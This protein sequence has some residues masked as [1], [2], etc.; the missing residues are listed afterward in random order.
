MSRHY[1]A[2]FFLLVTFAALALPATADIVTFDDGALHTIDAANSFP[3]DGAVIRDSSTGNPTTVVIQPGGSFGSTVSLFDTSLLQLN[4]GFLGSYVEAGD[5]AHIDIISGSVGSGPSAVG[6][7][8]AGT[9]AIYGGVLNGGLA[10]APGGT[11]DLMGGS[12]TGNLV[13]GDNGTIVVHGTDFNMPLG[14]VGPITGLLTGTLADGTSL[15]VN[16]NRDFRGIGYITLVPEPSTLVLLGAGAIS[17]L[18]C[19]WRRRKRTA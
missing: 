19:V 9:A 11:I 18:A 16:F 2:V 14:S 7:Y 12:V 13:A 4:G 15:S 1:R 3:S 5:S 17:L 6:V 8:A 10:A